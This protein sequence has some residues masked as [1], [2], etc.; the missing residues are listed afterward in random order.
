M[1]KN[2]D[3]VRQELGIVADCLKLGGLKQPKFILSQFWTLEVQNQGQ[4]PFSGSGEDPFLPLL[5]AVGS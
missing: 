1:P 5:A 3:S 2:S 4:A